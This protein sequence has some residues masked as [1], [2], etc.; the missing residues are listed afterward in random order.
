VSLLKQ[1]LLSAAVLLSATPSIAL[2]VTAI[3]ATRTIYPG[4]LVGADQVASTALGQCEGC[5]PGFIA[6][7]RGIVGKIAIRTILPNRLIYPEAIRS[8]SIIQK[9]AT[10]SLIYRSGS[11]TISVKAVSLAVA[12]IGEPVSVRSQLNGNVVTGIVQ[13]DGSVLAGGS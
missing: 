4:Q 6:D 8:P 11:L 10:T 3:V 12:A 13:A 9:G 2:E 5:A 1:L 7:T